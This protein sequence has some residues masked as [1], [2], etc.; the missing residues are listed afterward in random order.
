MLRGGFPH[1]SSACSVF[2]CEAVSESGKVIVYVLL[3]LVCVSRA[4]AIR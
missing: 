4:L 3:C 2:L 1:V